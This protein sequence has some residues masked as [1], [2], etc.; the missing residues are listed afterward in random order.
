MWPLMV[1][2]AH[3]LF[4]HPGNLFKVMRTLESGIT[5][6][7]VENVALKDINQILR[8]AVAYRPRLP[9]RFRNTRS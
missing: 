4:D 8:R 9:A 1:V 7:E 3:G 5:E 2:D 6:R